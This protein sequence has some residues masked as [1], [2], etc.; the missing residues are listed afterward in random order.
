MEYH[1]KG[2]LSEHAGEY[3]GDVFKSL[4]AFRDIVD[5]VSKLHSNKIVHRDIKP[6]N[7]FVANDGRLVLGD[8]GL[9]FKLQNQE[10]LLTLPK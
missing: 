4:K 10:R 8:C 5:A 3:K 7:I 2:T 6:D 9:A 1:E